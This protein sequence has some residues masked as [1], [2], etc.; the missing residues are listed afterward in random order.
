M[1]CPFV[2]SG[3]AALYMILEFLPWDWSLSETVY[4]AV[5]ALKKSRIMSFSIRFCVFII[6]SELLQVLV[7]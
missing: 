6:I 3:L 4:G 5:C 7:L 2:P 1:N